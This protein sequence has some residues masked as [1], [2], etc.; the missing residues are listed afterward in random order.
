MVLIDVIDG[1]QTPV[2][3]EANSPGILSR[4]PNQPTGWSAPPLRHGLSTGLAPDNKSGFYGIDVEKH[5]FRTASPRREAGGDGTFA[6]V[7]APSDGDE[8]PRLRRGGSHHETD[9][10]RFD[11]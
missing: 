3:P 9:Q 1:S 11:L 8:P 10:H 6:V 2:V 7:G 5:R 4:L